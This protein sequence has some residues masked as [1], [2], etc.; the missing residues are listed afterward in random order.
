LELCNLDY[1]VLQ[2]QVCTDK[3][4]GIQQVCWRR[5]K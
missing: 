1:A 5:N 2:V 4:S 3:C